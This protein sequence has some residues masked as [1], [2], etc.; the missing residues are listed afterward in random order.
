MGSYSCMVTTRWDLESE[1]DCKIW[2]LPIVNTFRERSCAPNKQC[3]HSCIISKSFGPSVK[4]SSPPCQTRKQSPHK[5]H[6]SSSSSPIL[7]LNLNYSTSPQNDW[8]GYLRGSSDKNRRGNCRPRCK[9]LCCG[10]MNVM[11]WLEAHL[12]M[13]IGIAR[14]CSKSCSKGYVYPNKFN[15]QNQ[16]ETTVY[17]GRTTQAILSRAH[18]T[19]SKDSTH[20]PF[21]LS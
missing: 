20:H 4:L 1:T 8:P 6:L 3:K 2:S 11:S 5:P 9:L 15:W 17:T 19:P 13:H 10:A 12:N 18:S 14:D 21:P 7:Q 16:S